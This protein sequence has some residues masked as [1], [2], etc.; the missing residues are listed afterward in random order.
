MKLIKIDQRTPEW[1]AWRNGEDLPD[2]L[3]RI[4]ATT[5]S[6]VAGTSRFKTKHQLW[7]EMTGKAEA[8]PAGFAA[9][10][11]AQKEDT[12]L[13]HYIQEVGFNV[14]PVCIQS[15]NTPW[16]AASLDGFNLKRRRAAEFK[17]NGASTHEMA[18]RGEIP[19]YYFDQM[20]WQI[21]ASDREIEI[22]DYFSFPWSDDVE[23]KGILIQVFPDEAR[24]KH[25]FALADEF[26]NIMLKNDIPPYSSDWEF[27]AREWRLAQLRKDEAE[28]KM[29]SAKTKLISLLPET[30]KFD[31]A[32]VSVSFTSGRKG[33]VDMKAA[34]AKFIAELAAKGVDTAWALAEFESI[35]DQCRKPASEG[36]YTIRACGEITGDQDTAVSGIQVITGEQPEFSF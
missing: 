6:I 13:K 28:A 32:G 33:S 4:T 10:K 5:A 27:A 14:A 1:H 18:A 12:V 35:Q 24:Q 7:R 36:S 19:P 34:T 20:Q 15:S 21:F 26:R 11:G 23:Q 17:C 8:P 9:K 22:V 29:E 25:L 30:R 2:G 3:P 16:V 31:G